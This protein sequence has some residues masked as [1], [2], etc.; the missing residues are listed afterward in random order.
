V[1]CTTVDINAYLFDELSA[2]E[3]Q[4]VEMHARACEACR[5]ELSRAQMTRDALCTL[6][7]QEIPQRIAFV[8]DK[9]FEPSLWARFWQSGPRLGFVSSAML[10]AAILVHGYMRP[11]PVVTAHQTVD[12]AAIERRLESEL[13]RKVAQATTA[14]EARQAR[15]TAELLDAAEKRYELDRQSLMAATAANMEILQKQVVKMYA[16]NQF[17][18]GQ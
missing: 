4:S 9:V 5:Q 6:R 18:A 7:E 2:N 15:K 10:A 14:V 16:S 12:T 11:A 8:S 3:R 17:G 13:A 1:N